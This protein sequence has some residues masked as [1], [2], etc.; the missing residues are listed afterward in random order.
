MVSRSIGI[1]HKLHDYKSIL[2]ALNLCTMSERRNM[3]DIKHLND[4]VF[5]VIY[6]PCFLARI[7]LGFRISKTARSRDAYYLVPVTRN[8]FDDDPLRRR[9]MYLVNS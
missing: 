2:T 9:A 7:G 1:I 8:C 6:S 5:G 4:L 3:N